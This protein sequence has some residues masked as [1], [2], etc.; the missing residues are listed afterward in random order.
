[1]SYPF[2]QIVGQDRMKLALTL[3]AI[4]PGLGGVLVSG[5]RGSAKSTAARGIASLLP[6]SGTPFVSLPIG[7]TEDRVLGTIDIERAIK[8]GEKHFEPGL[9]SRAHGGV[10]YVDEVNLL[11][12][13]LVDI[14]L[15]VAASGVNVVEREGISMS[16]PARF[17]LVGTMN[18]DEGE[19]RPQLLDRFGITVGVE[20]IADAGTRA[21]AVRRALAFEGDKDA[22]LKE[23]VRAEDE[24]RRKILA[25]RTQIRDVVVPEAIAIAISERCTREGVEGLR[26]DLAIRRSAI[27]LAAWESRKTVTADDVERV[28]EFALAHRRTQRPAPAPPPPPPPPPKRPPPQGPSNPR[29]LSR[30]EPAPVGP[31][32]EPDARPPRAET[33]GGRGSPGPEGPRGPSIR[34]TPGAGGTLALD[35][36]LRAA[37]TRASNP[38]K[39]RPEDLRFRIRKPPARRLFLFVLDASRSMGA[40][41]RMEITKGVLLGLLDKAYQR[42]DEVALITFQGNEAT[43]VLP[44]TRSVRRVQSLV[45]DLPVGGRTPL[46][47]ALAVARATLA[48]SARRQSGL[49]T[50][51]LLVSD[52]RPTASA[53]GA[54]PCAAAERQLAALV[55]AL[56]LASL[57]QGK[58][59]CA[60][61]VLVDTEEGS[62]RLGFMPEWS[63]RWNL[64]LAAL[65][66]LH[67]LRSPA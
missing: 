3:A 16:H 37:A 7:A 4:H 51:I 12:D 38:F 14:L 61:L 27:A 57:A 9:L 30:F 23:A 18:P 60:D 29:E 39:I 20:D 63:K 24:L 41:R 26:A 25:A 50:T 21:E 36:T 40:R 48:Q 33:A 11:P 2:S 58:D 1:M 56:R 66:E 65:D 45:R 32:R 67:A 64:R 43:L 35:A 22:F 44:P 59:A 53:D 46:D 49:A 5:H 6:G 31:V 15:D 34:S 42:R 52:G 10:L 54:D 28:A 8:S 19:L 47:R 62:P 13:H 17:I 55:A